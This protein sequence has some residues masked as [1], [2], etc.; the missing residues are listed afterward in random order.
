MCGLLAKPDDHYYLTA[1]VG[2]TVKFPCETSLNESVNWKRTD[3]Y[4]YI[5]RRSAYAA[6]ID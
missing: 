3:R 6:G 2:Q 4:E 1:V 5:Y